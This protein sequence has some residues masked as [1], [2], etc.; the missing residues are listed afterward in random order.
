M[1][2]VSRSSHGFRKRPS[3]QKIAAKP[4]KTII[5]VINPNQVV[6]DSFE[7]SNLINDDNF[8]EDEMKNKITDEI[9]HDEVQREIERRQKWKKTE[10]KEQWWDDKVPKYLRIYQKC[11]HNT[12]SL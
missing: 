10:D 12:P 7:F 4:N 3:F 6:R 2:I 8:V 9:F 1:E 5:Y 11:Q